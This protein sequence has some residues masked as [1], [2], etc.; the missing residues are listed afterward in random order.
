[1]NVVVSDSIT[2]HSLF[3]MQVEILAKS[4]KLSVWIPCA[5]RLGIRPDRFTASRCGKSKR[6]R[7]LSIVFYCVS[8]SRFCWVKDCGSRFL[9]ISNVS[10]VFIIHPMM[11]SIKSCILPL[12]EP[13]EA[14]NGW[15]RHW[16]VRVAEPASYCQLKVN[17]P[18]VVSPDSPLRLMLF[19]AAFV[20]T[21]CHLSMV[22]LLNVWAAHWFIERVFLIQLSRFGPKNS[23]G[24]RNRREIASLACLSCVGC[25]R[26]LTERS[27]ALTTR[28][29]P[30]T[31]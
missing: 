29:C 6:P 16:I 7:M 20:W 25:P 15:F 28:S 2:L 8:L 24:D 26:D 31:A 30:P 11:V 9:P 19:A 27:K 3:L 10:L 5:H 14:Q 18:R 1:M 23:H 17:S 21:A 12:T 22:M 4:L 13:H